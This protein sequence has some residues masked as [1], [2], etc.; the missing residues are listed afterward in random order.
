MLFRE[1]AY[2]LTITASRFERVALVLLLTA[3]PAFG[4]YVFTTIAVPGSGGTIPRGINDSGEIVGN[5]GLNHGF[6]YS[7]GA[8]TYLNVPGAN[9]GSTRVFGVNNLGD[10]VGSYSLF[11]GNGFE[12]TGGNFVSLHD[13]GH[14]IQFDGINN[15]GQIVGTYQDAAGIH[16]LLYSG[17]SLTVFDA[18]GALGAAA[19]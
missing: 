16:G 15:L 1:R 11:G 14:T 7:G 6:I 18:P 10:V 9:A 13:A 5:D 19:S 3:S 2:Q 17:G 4:G 8:F 12:Y